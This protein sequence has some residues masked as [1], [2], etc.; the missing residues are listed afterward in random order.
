MSWFIEAFYA[1]LVFYLMQLNHRRR[2][3]KWV[4]SNWIFFWICDWTDSVSSAHEIKPAVTD[5]LATR[6]AKLWTQSWHVLSWYWQTAD[7]HNCKSLTFVWSSVSL[8]VSQTSFIRLFLWFYSPSTP[9]E[10]WLLVDNAPLDLLVH[11][12]I[13]LMYVSTLPM[14]LIAVCCGRSYLISYRY[15]GKTEESN[16]DEQRDNDILRKWNHSVTQVDTFYVQMQMKRCRTCSSKWTWS[17]LSSSAEVIESSEMTMI[18]SE[19]KCG[20]SRAHLHLYICLWVS[21]DDFAL[22]KVHLLFHSHW[23]TIWFF[24]FHL[25]VISENMM[26][27]RLLNAGCGPVLI[28]AVY[29]NSRSTTVGHT[30]LMAGANTWL[31][32]AQTLWWFYL[33]SP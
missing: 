2:Q 4:V 13:E 17:G 25:N 27:A 30:W 6:R 14:F 32:Q 11:I 9:Q 31:N 33:I 10:I 29:V 3:L 7:T 28:F 12:V 23:E 24:M 26:K 8:D 19:S 16:G 1:T 22:C 20:K 5:F 21:D 18:E 15:V